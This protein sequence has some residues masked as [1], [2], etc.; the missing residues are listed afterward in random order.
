MVSRMVTL[1]LKLVTGDFNS[2]YWISYFNIHLLVLSRPV[3]QT[4][5][6][7]I[8]SVII[9]NGNDSQTVNKANTGPYW[10]IWNPS[11]CKLVSYD[12]GLKTSPINQEVIKRIGGI[13]FQLTNN[14]AGNDSD[15]ASLF[16]CG[17][18]TN[19]FCNST[20]SPHNILLYFF[21]KF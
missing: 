7:G 10:T 3:T 17:F 5:C 19:F 14:M 12:H 18:P 1:R 15:L 9:P 16:S 21:L 4:S 6:L 8:I 11:H 13:S 2:N 20:F